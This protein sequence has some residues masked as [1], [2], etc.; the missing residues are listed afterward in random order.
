[1][2][3]P[4]HGHNERSVQG[5]NVPKPDPLAT[6]PDRLRTLYEGKSRASLLEFTGFV[7]LFLMSLILVISA[8]FEQLRFRDVH[9]S[10]FENF[11]REF[12]GWIAIFGVVIGFVAVMTF[13]IRKRNR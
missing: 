13:A 6:L 4:M 5:P 7:I 12:G 1:M 8:V 10:G 3:S 9:A 2:P 11:V